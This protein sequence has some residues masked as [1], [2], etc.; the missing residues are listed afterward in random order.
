MTKQGS[1]TYDPGRDQY[2]VA[3]SGANMW[4]DRDDFQFVWK[5]IQGNFILTTR[6]GFNGPGVDPHRKFGWSVRSGLESGSPHV[7]AAVHGDGLVALQFRRSAGGATE[8]IRSP[9]RGADVVQLER[10]G[11]TYVLSVGRF[12][13]SLAPV[14]ITDLALGNE[15]Y[16]GLFV[17]AHNDTVVERAT[18]RDVR[19]TAPARD[20]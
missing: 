19:I 6:A 5:R 13:D 15:V 20:G 17:C 12:G 11:D 14:R 3:G 9:V 18:F 2:A 4:F 8:E 1:V 10:V 16:V 7:T